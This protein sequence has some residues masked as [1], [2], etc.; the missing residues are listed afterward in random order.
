[1]PN[2]HAD[3]IVDELFGDSSPVTRAELRQVLS[4]TETMLQEMKQV[5]N[6]H[7][8]IEMFHRYVIIRTVP[9]QLLAKLT[10]EYRAEREASNEP[11][12]DSN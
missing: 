4:E 8:E 1:M 6:T 11:P 5:I 2:N 9:E 12:K 7:A 3:V 10:Q